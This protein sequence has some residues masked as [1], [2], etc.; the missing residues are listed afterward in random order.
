MLDYVTYVLNLTMLS[1]ISIILIAYVMKTLRVSREYTKAK[2]IIEEVIL[3]FN[4]DVDALKNKIDKLDSKL[5]SLQI[6]EMDHVK[7]EIKSLSSKIKELQDRYSVLEE[8]ISEIKAS[9]DKLTRLS[10]S[11][12][13][14]SKPTLPTESIF[15]LKKET[16]FSLTPTELKILEIL[17]T[18]GDKTVREIRNRIGLTREHTG[19]L[20]KSLYDK[21]Y[22]ER[23]TNRIPYVYRIKKEM[24]EFLAK[25]NL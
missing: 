21:G 8:K 9:A 18:E 24:K 2:N 14:Q 13:D 17:A 10:R 11:V 22:I 7:S 20:M 16:I 25:K 15:P 5:Q 4:K 6:P 23:R 1:V 19:R 3:S 12:T